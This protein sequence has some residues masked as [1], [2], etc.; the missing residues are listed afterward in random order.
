MNFPRPKTARLTPRFGSWVLRYCRMF[1]L[2]ESGPRMIEIDWVSPSPDGQ[3]R[4][5]Y[6]M[7]RAS[8]VSLR[9]SSVP[10][11]TR[12][13]RGEHR[14]STDRSVSRRFRYNLEKSTSPA[15]SSSR[16]RNIGLKRP[17]YWTH[18]SLSIHFLPTHCRSGLIVCPISCLPLAHCISI[19][20]SAHQRR[21]SGY[22]H[23]PHIT[24]SAYSV[25]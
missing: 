5:K 6:Q 13:R 4:L 18:G 1:E 24:C 22:V 10:R 20:S 7:L 11:A 14:C 16:P 15:P 3:E 8:K 19:Q 21:S 23:L 12:S 2:Y 17:G 9:W 25:E